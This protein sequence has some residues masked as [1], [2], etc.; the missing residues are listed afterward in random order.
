MTAKEKELTRQ[1]QQLKAQ[2][3]RAL[4]VIDMA[5]LRSIH[6]GYKSY[7]DEEKT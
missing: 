1:N 6:D 3:E 7:L 2:L 5:G 4:D